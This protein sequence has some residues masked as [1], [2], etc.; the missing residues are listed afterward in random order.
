MYLIRFALIIFISLHVRY[1][2]GL[3]SSAIENILEDG[4]NS[5]SFRSLIFWVTNELGALL[6]LDEQVSR[7]FNFLLHIL[8][9]I[10]FRY[11]LQANPLNL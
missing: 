9:F 11:I 6:N 10:I 3:Q 1:Q 7:M 5:K 8:K 4:I 2:E